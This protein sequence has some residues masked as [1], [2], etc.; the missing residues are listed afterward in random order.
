MTTYSERTAFPLQ[1]ISIDHLRRRVRWLGDGQCQ[2]RAILDFLHLF[3]LSIIPGQVTTAQLEALWST[4][5]WTV[6]RRMNAIRQ[7]GVCKVIASR[8]GYLVEMLEQPVGPQVRMQTWMKQLPAPQR[9]DRVR[10]L[11]RAAGVR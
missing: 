3:E 5:Q 1:S 9:W 6:C 4:R 7:L 10:E 8:S 11:L 2:D